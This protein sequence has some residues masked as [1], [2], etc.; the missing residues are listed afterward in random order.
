MS[1]KKKQNKLEEEELKD[2]EQLEVT[3]KE[4]K[5]EEPPK[6]IVLNRCYR[7]F[8]FV[9]LCS[10]EAMTN[11]S[12]GLLAS[13]SINIKKSLNLN[14]QQFGNFGTSNGI[15]RIVGSVLFTYFNN[16]FS[17]KWMYFFCVAIKGS[18]VC[19]FKLTSN[20]NVL[21][22]IR[23]FIGFMHMIPTIYL[24]SWI[25]QYGLKKYKNAQMATIQLA[26]PAGKFVAFAIC[27]VVGNDNW[28]TGFVIEGLYLY[29]VAFCTFISHENYFSRDYFPRRALDKHKE[30][31]VKE[32]KE[33]DEDK[34]RVTIFEPRAATEDT[35]KDNNSFFQD[36]SELLRNSIFLMACF[37]RA[38]LFGVN[39]GL[40]FWIADFMRKVIGCNDD[41]V[42]FIS[43]TVICIAGPTGGILANLFLKPLLGGYETRRASWS[44]VIIHFIAACFGVALAAAPNVPV[45][46]FCTLS[47]FIFNSCSLPNVQGI[48]TVSIDKRLS[49]TGSSITSMATILL[50]SGPAPVFYG[51]IN[52]NY[53]HIWKGL[54]MFCM[55]SSHF[56]ALP[57]LITLAYKRDE[58][59][60]KHDAEVKKLEGDKKNKLLEKN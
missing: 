57:F 6:K 11:C 24:S 15:G 41:L 7:F 1:S 36:L 42:I 25:D 52:D 10:T 27:M 33:D 8:L 12:S 14:D 4:E 34:D 53:K 35:S 16:K 18:L 60:D 56:L 54:A 38:V 45:F 5:E 43:Y 32:T 44:V 17:R 31:G 40:H 59:F 21:I 29:F 9:I 49:V 28:Q 51:W 2:A 39:T 19:C 20:A 30:E 48:L 37:S 26:S 47:Y 3:E 55:Q 50:I 46:L 23:C 22:V 13:A 58:L